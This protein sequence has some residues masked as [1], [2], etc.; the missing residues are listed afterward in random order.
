MSVHNHNIQIS[1]KMFNQVQVQVLARAA[2]DIQR[3]REALLCYFGCVLQ[4]VVL[5]EDEPLSQS[6]V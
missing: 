4:L 1:P 2:E 3:Y 5:L 6:E